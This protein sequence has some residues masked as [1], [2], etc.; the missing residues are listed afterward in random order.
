MPAVRPLPIERLLVTR[1]GDGGPDP[2]AD[3]LVVEA[4]LRISLD[5]VTVTTTMRTP[6]HDAELAAGFVFTDGLLG[7]ASIRSIEDLAVA[8]DPGSSPVDEVAV[9]SDGTA[10]PPTARLGNVSSS[11]GWCGHG[12]LDELTDWLAPLPATEPIA[13][14]VLATIAGRV[15]PEQ[16]LFAATGAVHAAA[17][18]DRG[19]TVLAVR[20]DVGRHNALDKLIGSMLLAEGGSRLPATGLGVFVSG[21]ASVE[22]VQKAWA[23]GFSTLIAVS[24]PT[25][26]AVHTARR[27][28]L[29]LVGFA[30]AGRFNEYSPGPPAGSP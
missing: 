8:L 11:C 22:T 18:F 29:G 24:A 10:P 9:T 30:R 1:V 21:R 17:S 5:G 6:G 4:P 13:G 26:L 14:A 20:E 2:T 15:A 7:A 28:G 12:R 16:P 3:D 27:A 25:A 23:A 19:G